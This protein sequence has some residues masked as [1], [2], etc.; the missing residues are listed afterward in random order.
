M[1]HFNP[2]NDGSLPAITGVKA[3]Q[4]TVS[5]ASAAGNY[6]PLDCIQHEIELLSHILC[7]KTQ[8]KIAVLLKQLVFSF[9][10]AVLFL[11]G[12]DQFDSAGEPL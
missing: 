3:N 7:E 9:P 4:R 8:D 5:V 10:S 2:P 11:L 12:C 1:S 6:G